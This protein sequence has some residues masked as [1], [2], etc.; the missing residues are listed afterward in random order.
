MLMSFP[1]SPQ[2]LDAFHVALQGVEYSTSL[3]VL[4][5]KKKLLDNLHAEVAE[6]EDGKLKRMLIEDETTLK[7]REACTNRLKLYRK[8]A[9]ELS[10]ASY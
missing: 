3:Q 6:S 7:R 4:Q 9:E 10:A 2:A 8:A 1:A 5:A